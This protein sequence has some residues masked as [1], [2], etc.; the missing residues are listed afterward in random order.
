MDVPAI[1]DLEASGF[2]RGSYPIE[3]AVALSDGTVISELIKPAE[4][5]VHWSEE[6]EAIHGL[7]REYLMDNG[8]TP[9]E[10]AMQ[11][12]ETLRGLVL[13]S[14]AWSF[15]SSWIGRLYD[16]ADLVQRFRIDTLNRLLNEDELARW[17]STKDA[18]VAKMALPIHR[19]GNDVQILRATFLDVKGVT[20][21]A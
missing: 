14:D 5:W 1:I 18:V 3:V 12:N 10:V 13:F 4:N 17:S 9:R 7:S 21:G 11:L 20:E 6:A 15:D 2:G 8:K 16:E 19:A